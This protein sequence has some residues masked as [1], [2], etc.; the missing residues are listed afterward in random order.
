MFSSTVFSM[1][2]GNTINICNVNCTKFLGHTIGTSPII[3]QK[4]TST[5]MKQQQI[6][7]FLQCIDKCSIQGE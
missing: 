2:S 7:Q 1:A 3:A 5:N 4:L 6:L